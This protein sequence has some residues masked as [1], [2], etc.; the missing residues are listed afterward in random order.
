[1]SAYKTPCLQK[2]LNYII[3]KYPFLHNHISE[4]EL[5]TKDIELPDKKIFVNEFFLH[6]INL[7]GGVSIQITWNIDKVIRDA[8]ILP[9][10][11][12]T[13]SELLKFINFDSNSV[14]ETLSTISFHTRSKHKTNIV[15]LAL[16]PNLTS[17]YTI[18]DGNHKI[19]ENMNNPDKVFNCRIITADNVLEYLAP[20]SKKFA[21]LMY[22][23]DSYAPNP[24]YSHVV[25]N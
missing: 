4:L 19:L 13:V 14:Q 12:Q 2:W 1:M 7:Y 11:E 17:I 20:E 18:I 5:I 15:F 24:L 10:K 3:I 9:Y 6:T 22:Q 23:L 8:P 16:F 25:E 21:K